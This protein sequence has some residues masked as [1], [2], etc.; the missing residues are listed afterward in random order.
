ME[1]YKSDNWCNV[2]SQKIKHT[3]VLKDCVPNV[4]RTHFKVVRNFM[5]KRCVV[6]LKYTEILS[7]YLRIKVNDSPTNVGRDTAV[8]KS[9]HR[10]VR[11]SNPGGAK[12]SPSSRPAGPTHTPVQLIPGNSR[13]ESGRSVALP[14]APFRVEVKERVELYFTF[15]L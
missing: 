5:Y 15:Y 2:T 9:N 7:G 3:F 1:V 13:G 12:F 10:T 14:P 8:G 4:R 11:G 6:T